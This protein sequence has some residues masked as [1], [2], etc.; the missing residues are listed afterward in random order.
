M[1]PDALDEARAQVATNALDAGWRHHL[2]EAG[3]KLRTMIAVLL[4]LAACLN[5]LA[6]MHLGRRAKYGHQ[7]PMATH[8]D[9]QNSKAGL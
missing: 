8:L 5:V 4:P 6:R 9:A 1:R 3:T 2:Q 7:I